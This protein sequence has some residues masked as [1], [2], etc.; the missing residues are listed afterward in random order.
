MK[1]GYVSGVLL[2]AGTAFYGSLLRTMPRGSGSPDLLFQ[3]GDLCGCRYR[4][5]SFT[6][7]GM[8]TCGPVGSTSSN[9]LSAI[10]H[11]T[12]RITRVI[13]LTS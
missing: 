11:Q 7:S 8:Y 1:F 6:V 3:S 9:S 12:Y 10:L 13:T 5:Y 4:A 2:F